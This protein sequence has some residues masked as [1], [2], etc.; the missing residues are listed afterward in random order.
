MLPTDGSFR[1]D[2][3]YVACGYLRRWANPTGRVWTYRILVPHPRV[4]YWRQS[5]PKSVAY[6]SNLYTRIV[7]GVETDEM[8]RWFDREFETPAAE[9]LEKATADARLTPEDWKV[10]IRYLA[11]QDLR[12]PARF[13]ERLKRWGT[14]MLDLVQATLQ[15]SV[16]QLEEAHALGH[17]LPARESV[18]MDGLPFRV[19]TRQQPG[20]EMGQV[21]AH[22]LLGRSLWLWEIRH[23]LNRTWE[24][25]LR[26]KWT[27]LKP[28]DGMTWFTS[29][30][31]VVRLNF[32][33]ETTYDFGGGWGSKGSE[34]LFP[35]GPHHLMYTQ[36]GGKPPIRG[37]T[38]P[39]Q[40]AEI[41]RRIMAEHA[42]RLVFALE[43]SD[44]IP[45]LRPRTED[46]VAWQQDRDQWT[47][48]HDEQ[49][50][51]ELEMMNRDDSGANDP[52][53]PCA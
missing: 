53:Q 17:P 39:P 16:R 51:A 29:D 42:Y 50:A 1:Q 24:A 35:L 8:E 44:D 30:N 46:T 11:A 27:I 28:P 32:S 15:E 36:I 43:P 3:H 47:R 20:E 49:R 21:G 23:A 19:E 34:I 38:M 31:P 5:S 25:L 45:R 13:E 14:E 18:D 9:A 12:T 22:L 37:E 40:Q 6:R 26:H 7:A 4:Q 41:V 52:P 33:S 10:L 48:W 2:N